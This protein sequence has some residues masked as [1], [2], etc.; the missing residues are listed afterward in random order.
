MQETVTGTVKSDVNKIE[1]VFYMHS[2]S[3]HMKYLMRLSQL[4]VRIRYKECEL[5]WMNKIMCVD[6]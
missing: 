6:S 2:E 5:Q 3:F 1:W 4:T